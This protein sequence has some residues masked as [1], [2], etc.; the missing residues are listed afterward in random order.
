MPK[1]RTVSIGTSL[2]RIGHD[3]FSL[4]WQFFVTGLAI[5]VFW[6]VPHVAIDSHASAADQRDEPEP[7]K[8]IGPSP[9]VIR[10][11]VRGADGRPVDKAEV[12]LVNESPTVSAA[13]AAET[14]TVTDSDGQFALPLT[15][16]A[17]FGRAIYFNVITHKPGV[18]IAQT[19]FDV[20][21]LPV[22]TLVLAMRQTVPIKMSITSPDGVPVLNVKTQ[23]RSLTDPEGGLF[24]LPARDPARFAR[25]T[26]ASGAVTFDLPRP[27]NHF[28]LEVEAPG[29]GRQLIWGSADGPSVA[30]QLRPVGKLR[31]HLVA[32]D[33]KQTGGARLRMQ[34]IN[35]ALDNSQI[36]V[37]GQAE[38]RADAEGHFEVPALA[39][40]DLHLFAL[41]PAPGSSIFLEQDGKMDY[42]PFGVIEAG[43]TLELDVPVVRGARVSGTVIDE[44]TL[45]PFPGARVHVSLNSVR[46]GTIAWSVLTDKAGRYDVIVP[47]GPGMGSVQ[48]GPLPHPFLPA[49]SESLLGEFPAAGESVEMPDFRVRRG[50]IL[51]GTVV[52]AQQRSVAR[53]HV[54]AGVADQPSGHYH[55]AIAETDSQGR[56]TI[57]PVDAD[58]VVALIAADDTRASPKPLLVEP[59]KTA[60]GIVLSID[61]AAM[62]EL[63]GRVVDRDGKPLVDAYIGAGPELPGGTWECEGVKVLQPIP[64]VS[65]KTDKEGKYVLPGRMPIW[66]R[67]YVQATISGHVTKRFAVEASQGLPG[68]Q[69]LADLVLEREPGQPKG[70]P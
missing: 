23:L 58:L 38:V 66:G 33:R 7:G 39:A 68:R 51:T 34:T 15:S 5:A 67:Y 40:G 1:R 55:R 45:Q 57:G 53:A 11:I 21:F 26:D 4:W 49:Q 3:R 36:A 6:G 32:D 2:G 62:V 46:L 47:P 30:L 28:G 59:W 63:A 37:S 31:G 54:Q 42:K 19:R 16:D 10:G 69:A 70:Q 64:S 50:V 61:A 60:R 22:P 56:F 20:R 43:A 29:Y 8:L 52:D 24:N 65:A 27:L 48:V 44:G 25:T 14:H 35:R 12:W 18:G 41:D 13:A 9:I 17:P